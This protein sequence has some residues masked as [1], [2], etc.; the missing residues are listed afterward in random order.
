M[1][2]VRIALNK[3]THMRSSYRTVSLFGLFGS[4]Q[5]KATPISDLSQQSAG[6]SVDILGVVSSI[7]PVSSITT[8]KGDPLSRRTVTLYDQVS[9]N[10]HHIYHPSHSSQYCRNMTTLIHVILCNLFSRR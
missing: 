6:A 2:S 9:G 4:V 8:K 5:F 1:F 10:S 3:Y 7:G